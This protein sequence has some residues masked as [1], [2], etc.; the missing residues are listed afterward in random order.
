MGSFKKFWD[1]KLIKIVSINPLYGGS[2]V[3]I[4]S[5]Y[6]APIRRECDSTVFK[7]LMDYRC[8]Y[9]LMYV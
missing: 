6:E 4:F 1:F 8:F 7:I 5:P 9:M 3:F 2:K